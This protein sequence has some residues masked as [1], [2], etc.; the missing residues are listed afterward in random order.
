MA[1]STAACRPDDGRPA[2][3]EANQMSI[4]PMVRRIGGS[5]RALPIWSRSPVPAARPAVLLVIGG[6][7]PLLRRGRW[8]CF[9]HRWRP[10]APRNLRTP[11]CRAGSSETRWCGTSPGFVLDP[12]VPVLQRLTL[13]PSGWRKTVPDRAAVRAEATSLLPSPD[14][15]KRNIVVQ[16]M[17]LAR[18]R[19]PD[20]GDD[21]THLGFGNAGY[22][23]HAAKRPV[24]LPHARSS[25]PA[26]LLVSAW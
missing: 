20:I 2:D 12:P 26:R 25:R 3:A 18:C 23:G 7:T 10:S 9:P 22:Q 19:V 13:V 6:V 5:R 4:M 21:L 1:G 14:R 11:S 24:M 15:F 16:R 8:S 17:P